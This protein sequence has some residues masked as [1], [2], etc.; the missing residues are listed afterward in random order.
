MTKWGQRYLIDIFLVYCP[1]PSTCTLSQP[2]LYRFLVYLSDRFIPSLLSISRPKS[3]LSAVY[4]P[5]KLLIMAKKLTKG[6]LTK[7]TSN[8]SATASAP[9][10]QTLT[11]G[12]PLPKLIVFDLDY[13]LWPFWVDTH[14][15]PPL[16][17]TSNHSSMNDKRGESFAFYN[18]VPSIIHSVTNI[19]SDTI[20]RPLL[21][22][23]SRTSA[24]DLALTML[25]G[26]YID[27]RKSSEFFDHQ[28][29][30]PGDKR[31]HFEKLQKKSDVDYKD[32]LFFDDEARNRNVETLGVTMWLIR[33]G[34]SRPEFDKGVEEWRKRRGIGRVDG[35]SSEDRNGGKFV[36]NQ[37]EVIDEAI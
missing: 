16:K 10:P 22:L 2:L 31:R 17:T 29:I 12:L 30:Y 9:A 32:M 18:D 34:V 26:L 35:E 11:D 33:D 37:G 3:L 27:K 20:A 4:L 13:T 5:P 36:G 23:A 15:I 14:V 8:T 7:T 19:Q 25:R 21:G 1:Q 28:E 24:P 6:G